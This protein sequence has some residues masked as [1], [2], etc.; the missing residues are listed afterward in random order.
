M[1][2]NIVRNSGRAKEHK[3][4][5]GGAAA[6]P[7]PF[8]GIVKNNVDPTR[9]GRL[10][11]F[12]GN[13]ADGAASDDASTWR[14]VS[15]LS[16]FYG[17]TQHSGSAAGE[18]SYVGNR[19][20]YGFWFTP[21]DIGTR[22]LCFFAE[23]DP[24]QGYYVGCIPEPGL[25]H[26]VP[27]IGAVSQ[28]KRDNA[29]QEELFG[30]ATRLPVAE[31]NDKNDKIADDPRFHDKVKPVHSYTAAI[32][33][34]QGLINDRVRGPIGSSAQRESPSAV[35]GLSTPGRPIYEGGMSEQT[36]RN[37]VASG[38]V[39][40]H[41]VKV[42]GRRGGH[43]FVLDDGDLEGNDALVRIRTARG[44]QLLMSDDGDSF[45]FIHA[46]GQA[47][48]EMGREGTVDV[49]STNSINL[50]TQGDL[51][52]HADKNIN[53]FAG[54]KLN[55]Y[56]VQGSHFE[57]AADTVSISAGNH[58]IH[59]SARFSI[60]A[61]GALSVKSDA[62][63][64]M[65]AASTTSLTG[66]K[67]NLNSGGQASVSAPAKIK[68]TKLTEVEF[69]ASKGWQQKPAK[70]ISIVSRA[71]THEPYDQHTKGVDAEVKLAP[72]AAQSEPP[73]AANPTTETKL[74][75]L[76]AKPVTQTINVAEFA[77]IE[78]V[79]EKVGN[80]T[81]DQVTGMLAQKAKSAAQLVSGIS[82]AGGIGKFGL[83]VDELEKLGMIKPGV[84]NLIKNAPGDIKAILE[85]ASSWTLKDGV[86]SIEQLLQSEKLQTQIQAR[87]L[88]AAHE[89]LEKAGVLGGIE[90]AAKIAGMV[91][92]AMDK[93]P[94]AVVNWA[95]GQVNAAVAE[96]ESVIS[97]GKAAVDFV[98]NKLP[99]TLA[100]GAQ[101]VGEF[102]TALR[103]GVDDSVNAIIANA[104]VPEI[105]FQVDK[106]GDL[107]AD[108]KAAVNSAKSFINDVQKQVTA[109]TDAVE[110][111]ANTV[112][113]AAGNI[114]N[115]ANSAI[116]QTNA[117]VSSAVSP[118]IDLHENLKGG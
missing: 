76:D 63:I 92:A 13:A 90:D 44:H 106:S 32:L 104:K 8:I 5:R 61:N 35:Y 51:N 91:S 39:K 16:P 28:A 62:S 110:N 26:M 95:K 113:D 20:S 54:K 22:V 45:H 81:S 115:T 114:V 117:V 9:S 18:G 82:V 118:I 102:G 75:A 56:S 41:E 111:A 68:Q 107:V 87:V 53:F 67:V 14:T 43:S 99:E 83:K 89:A 71:P 77:N 30:G 84:A 98:T 40:P 37:K 86:S 94:D 55:A 69:D 17:V 108:A 33:F 21:P 4:D 29:K 105:S 31:L 52:F 88:G 25:T 66:S 78:K 116:A 46:N 109:V 65:S 7:G 3:L 101:Q 1:A 103:Q 24:N 79:T 59:S 19:H 38:E 34:Q 12:V 2:E 60:L 85:N 73:K 23:G 74:A 97:K 96:V 48:I 93:G 47:W 72:S 36:V 27:A 49:Y 11:V 112:R 70:L 10:Q 80:L 57:T 15:Y 42:I 6:D 50:R 58:V 100:T 64:A